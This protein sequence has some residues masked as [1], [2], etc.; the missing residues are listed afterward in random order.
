MFQ[1]LSPAQKQALLEALQ[2][3]ST[4][5]L[6][7]PPE[8]PSEGFLNPAVN[9]LGEE[10]ELEELRA[11][12]GVTIVVTT[13]FKEDA[14]SSDITEFM[15]D[16]YRSGLLG[17]H[18]LKIGPGGI[19][20]I[21]GFASVPLAGLSADE[22]AIRLASE[23]QLKMLDV[24]VTILPL[25]LTGAE[26]LEPFGYSLFDSEVDAFSIQPTP[27][28]PVPRDY[29]IG[30]GDFL[31]VQFYGNENYS[32]SLPVNQDGTIN[33]PKVGPRS[34]AGL[35]FDEVK[36]AIEERIDT[37]LIGTEAAVTMGELRSIRV[38]VVGDV[39]RPGAYTMSSLARVT[40]ALFY[41]G[42]ITEIGSLRKI[43]L[44]RKD[45]LIHTLDLYDLL[46]RGNTSHDAQLRAD[47]VI[48]IP[49]AE[50]MVSVDGDVKR[51][52]IYEL[53]NERSITEVLSLAGGLMPTADKSSI[54]LERIEAS[55]LRRVETLNINQPEGKA[56]RLQAGD[57]I[58]VFQVPEEVLD[59]VF[60]GGH[61]TRPGS[62]EWLPDMTIVDLIPADTYLKPKADLGYVLI[63]REL[64]ADRQAQV[65]SA[66]LRAALEA[67]ASE[68]N[69]K[70]VNRDRVTI[71][72]LG[73]ARTGAIRTLLAELES[74][75]TRDFPM[76]AVTISGQVRAPGSYPLEPGMRLSDL[77]RAGSG[78]NAAAFGTQAELTR[79]VIDATG[80]RQTQ[81]IDVDLSA[82]RGG[83]SDAD[84]L[85][86]PYDYLN[87][88][89]VP[90]WEEQFEIELVGQVRFPGVYPVRRGETL[91]NVLKRAGGLTEQAFLQGSLF[92]RESL[93]EREAQQIE[94]LTNRLETDLTTLA[95]QSTTAAGSNSQQAMGIG[96]SLLQ[97]LRDSKPTG[98]LVINLESVVDHPGNLDYDIVVRDGDK[99]MIPDLS[100]E[101]MV[102]GEVQ[103]ATSH[104][105]GPGLTRT[106]YIDLS[107][108]TTSNADKKR[109]Y[110]VRANGAVVANESSRWYRRDRVQMQPG[111]TIVVPPDT[112]RMPKLA[113]WSSITQIIFNL[114]VAVAAV[115]SF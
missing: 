102:L 41:S 85:L 57:L 5:D 68:A 15:T 62:Y 33:F 80:K 47:D 44:K 19:L 12:G 92:T 84:M 107:G 96:Q 108:G 14:A 42:G 83:D 81:L 101:I 76:Q 78:L 43:Q 8:E 9:A 40:T 95:L 106:G 21:P 64:G 70:L 63:R 60:L 114:A 65:L 98:R 39:K 104:L 32:V 49:P 25:M 71:F 115:N 29:V 72:E 54:R 22:I 58:S 89:E 87:I 18:T 31:Q 111:D 38:F 55:G 34:V 93:Q 103:Y 50:S 3:G 24:E 28:A 100:Q 90:A 51:P 113:Q 17:S 94:T 26:A 10:D 99:L 61:V 112:D 35:T 36:Q 7:L 30:P 46:L 105:Y 4:Q 1:N 69:I 91:S 11:E 27:Y 77:I 45:K 88:K 59:A 73:I 37:Q 109:I 66:D 67:P 79:Y 52:A 56:T 53:G 13:Q 86:A 23:P 82:V 48:F 16:I 2:S 20:E 74:Q 110:V 75:A 6:T 97:Q